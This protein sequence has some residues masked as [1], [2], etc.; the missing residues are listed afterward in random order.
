M[1]KVE[2]LKKGL[3][4]VGIEC[5]DPK[6]L[7]NK[8]GM[9]MLKRGV[10][11]AVD[12]ADV[13]TMLVDFVESGVMFPTKDDCQIV[14]AINKAA[15][16]IH[17]EFDCLSDHVQTKRQILEQISAIIWRHLDKARIRRPATETAE[18]R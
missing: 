16:Q 6:D 1:D 10:K 17:A 7:R 12:P 15:E 13:Q 3:A 9:F 4:S 2:E 14:E 18:V 5:I 8:A 11:M